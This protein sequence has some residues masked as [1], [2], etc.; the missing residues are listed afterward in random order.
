M[1]KVRLL[2]N[3]PLFLFLCICFGLTVSAQT[4]NRLLEGSI[5]EKGKNNTELPV[6]GAK[7]IYSKKRIAFTDKEGKFAIE[8]PDTASSLIIQ[9]DHIGS[10]TIQ[11]TDLNK[12]L[13]VVYPMYQKIK[14]VVIRQKKFST[15]ISLLSIQKEERI[16]SKELL[17]AAC[18]NLG[19]SF[20]TTPSVDVAFTDAI[21]GYRQIQ[22]LG[23]AGP[24]TL[25]TRENIPEVRGLAAVT[26]LTFTPGQWIESMQLSKGT[27]SVVNGFEG[28]AGQINIELRKPMEGD[29]QFYNLYQSNQGRTEANAYM[30]FEP[31][32]RLYTNVFFH[33][34]SQ[35]LKIDQN[36]DHFIDQPLGESV[37]AANRWMWFGPNGTEVQGGVKYN[38]A[39]NWGGSMHI[40]ADDDPASSANWGLRTTIRR[41]DAWSKLGKV[42]VNQPW[43]SM[44]L[45]LAFSGHNQ[46][47]QFGRK[48]YN[49]DEN[50]LFA[51]YI[52]QSIIK[53]TNRVIKFGASAQLIRRNEHVVEQHFNTQEQ[54]AG[55][56]SE[57]SHIFSKK[58]SAVLGARLDYHQLYGWYTTPRLHIRYAP[59]DQMA[60]RASIGKSYRTATIFSENLG[61]FATNRQVS[62]VPSQTD[63]A[64]G[65]KNEKAINAGANATYT[66]KYRYQP[67]TLSADYYYTHFLGQV[68]AD[69]E[70][71]RHIRFYYSEKPS[72][73]HSVQVQADYSPIRKLDIRLAYRFHDVQTTY[74][75]TLRQ[76]PLNARH[77]AFVNVSYETRNKWAF[78]YTLQWTGQKR[79]PSTI[80]N[81][82]SLQWNSLSPSF[83]TMNAHVNKVLKRGFEWYVGVENM[84]NFMQPQAILDAGNPFGNFFDGSLIWG[85]SM[86]R[87]I[88]MGIRYKRK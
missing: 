10:D 33:A 67:V 7:I 4:P 52:Y 81:P 16:S 22:L 73:A 32:K 14:D 61:L 2:L 3:A 8:I 48:R 40:Q 50:S 15:E 57:Y 59:I 80:E 69:W 68:V 85:P 20:E 55:I 43:K 30:A 64:Y 86:G 44:G 74:N 9:F 75:E 83:I 60:I 29:K 37:I 18:C 66:F 77:R 65:L 72:F 58:V 46:H 47:M 63:G 70:S 12:E 39:G 49:A 28:L 82:E 38:Y 24:Y 19:E 45:Q 35:W 21:T 26:G 51:N 79:I 25:I 31:A 42:F 5:Y 84:L 88:Y 53:N 11:L 56:F 54:V 17:K 71:A 76:R 41:V 34:K 87:N 23:L 6:S 62:I 27:G 36:H 78:D 1:N 13:K